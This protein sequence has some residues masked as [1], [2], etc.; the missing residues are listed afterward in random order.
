M[1]KTWLKSTNSQSPIPGPM[2]IETN[3]LPVSQTV[4]LINITNINY[5]LIYS[6]QNYGN[7][8]LIK[9]TVTNITWESTAGGKLWRSCDF[10]L[11]L[12]DSLAESVHSQNSKWESSYNTI[13]G[14]NDPCRAIRTWMTNTVGDEVVQSRH[15]GWQPVPELTCDQMHCPGYKWL[16]FFLNWKN[17]WTD[18]KFSDD[19]N[20]IFT[21]G[22]PRTTILLHRDQSFGETLDQAQF[23]CRRLCW[24]MTKYDMRI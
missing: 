19:E 8:R 11:A 7:Y 14:C 9:P 12:P 1:V 23:S 16:L 22:R 4:I 18:T 17:S 2:L 3:T 24:K 6:R 20:V 13:M 10:A 5:T 15:F 21:A